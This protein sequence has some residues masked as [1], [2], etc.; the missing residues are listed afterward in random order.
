MNLL[1]W[2]Q[3]VLKWDEVRIFARTRLRDRIVAP[4]NHEYTA[5]G[6]SGLIC[7]ARGIA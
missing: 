6:R 1:G 4:R 7:G 5:R 3:A 2:A